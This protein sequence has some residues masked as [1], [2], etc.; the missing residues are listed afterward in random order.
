MVKRSEVSLTGG[1]FNSN[2]HDHLNSFLTP[3]PYCL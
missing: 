2:F 1:S 3:Y